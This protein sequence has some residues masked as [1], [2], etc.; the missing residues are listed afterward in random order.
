[1]SKRFFLL[2]KGIQC[3]GNETP[4]EEK[5]PTLNNDQQPTNVGVKPA[6]DDIQYCADEDAGE[7]ACEF[8]VTE[9]EPEYDQ[10]TGQD[11]NYQPSTESENSG[12]ESETD[13]EDNTHAKRPR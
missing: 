8:D 6:V 12:S 2:Y 9:E 7:D 10:D 5:Q 11:G 13:H 1:M 4:V 3:D